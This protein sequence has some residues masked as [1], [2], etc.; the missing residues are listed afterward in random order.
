MIS[1]LKGKIPSDL[2]KYRPCLQTDTRHSLFLHL[3]YVNISVFRADLSVQ[4]WAIRINIEGFM[5]E[6][7][8]VI[9]VH[10]AND[11]ATHAYNSCGSCYTMH[12]TKDDLQE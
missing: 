11:L 6:C 3:G 4:A 1:T 8:R 12:G 7:V 5:N 2:P 9:E 10:A